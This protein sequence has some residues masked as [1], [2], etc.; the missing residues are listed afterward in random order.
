[1]A[2]CPSPQ[3]MNRPRCLTCHVLGMLLTSQIAGVSPARGANFATGSEAVP[4]FGVYEVV[5]QGEDGGGN[6]FDTP[7][8]LRFTP[9]SGPGN[10][11]TVW[12]FYDGDRTWRAR[13]YAD[14]TGEWTW[15]ATCATDAGLN[16]RSGRF[17]CVPSQL[18]GR[19]LPHPRNPRQWIT[20]SGRWFLN[21]SDTAYFLL[22][23]QDGNGEP[24]SEEDVR[25]YLSDDVARGITSIRCFLASRRAG[26]AES[27][28]QWREWY[29]ADDA[30]DRLRLENLQCADRRLRLL[31][32]E[33]PKLAVQ[34][35]MFPLEAYARDDRFWA[36]MTGSQRER[37]LRQLVARFAA[38]PQLLWL[39]TNDAHYGEGFPNSNAMAREVGTY[40]RRH[41][42]WQHPRSTGH[43]RRVPFFFGGED[44]ATYIHIEHAHDLGALQYQQYDAF[45]KPVFLGE[46]RYEQD[47]GDVDP[48]HMQYWQRRLFWAWLL[49]GGSANY[50][51]RWWAVQPYS[52]TGTRTAT[53]HARPKVT[54][55]APLCG[56]D[57][58]L[59]IREYFDR[60][61]IDLGEFEPDHALVRD[62]DGRAG[63]QSPRL[64]R[65]GREEFL[66]Y[67][68]NAEADGREA[69][70][71]AATTARF[72]LDLRAA[73]GEFSV[74]WY[75]AADGVAADGLRVMAGGLRELTAPWVGED[76]VVRLLQ[77]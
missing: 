13:V 18:P 37:V 4:R 10:A 55:R 29:F 52:M 49:S 19:L 15:S 25:Q 70:V 63:A 21:L 39:I 65:R 2:S 14:E 47:H 64:M 26:F 48:L 44:W 23:A 20:E 3:V 22:C 5:L 71:D 11:K 32:D 74:E 8:A 54:F 53:Y 60:R 31:L 7:L 36:A 46:D 28:E 56:L 72:D 24:V 30:G 59:N 50:G 61:A 12:A 16:D 35:I 57:S 69:Q 9:P 17:R 42:P 34:L 41:D 1:M 67:H 43:A 73:A 58:V 51:G 66:I 75:R 27:T 6:P 40:L 38:Y 76:V 45:A 62:A 33:Y 77:R 68:P